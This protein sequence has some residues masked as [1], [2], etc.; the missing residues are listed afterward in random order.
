MFMA[1]RTYMEKVRFKIGVKDRRGE[2]SQLVSS[3]KCTAYRFTQHAATTDRQSQRLSS[4]RD[5]SEQL[6]QQ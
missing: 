3:Y 6:I 1:G 5:T 2:R 4:L